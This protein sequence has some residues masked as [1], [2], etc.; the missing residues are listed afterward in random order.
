MADSKPV[1]VGPTGKFPEGKLSEEDEG[2]LALSIGCN[3]ENRLVVIDFGKK[4]T[5]IGMRPDQAKEFADTIL[6]HVAT[7]QGN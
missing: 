6:K 5:W 2:E 4:V 3:H 7:L 1:K